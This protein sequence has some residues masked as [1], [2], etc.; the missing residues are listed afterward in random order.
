MCEGRRGERAPFSLQSR[1]FLDA[2]VCERDPRYTVRNARAPFLT[3]R[4]S[5]MGC[6]DGRGTLRWVP[7]NAQ[8][9]WGA[10]RVA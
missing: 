3:A 5:K 2:L 9:I 10:R 6:E 7:S 8:W 1:G 4:S